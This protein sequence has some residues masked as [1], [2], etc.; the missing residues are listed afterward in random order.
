MQFASLTFLFLFFPMTLGLYRLVPHRWKREAMLVISVL[1][2][3]GGGLLSAGV[4]LLLT[5]L[6]FFAGWLMERWKSRKG[7]SGL[8]LTG[9]VLGYLAVLVLLRSDWLRS[10]K[11]A[12]LDGTMF[13]PLGLAFFAL[14]GVG[15]CADVRRG[16]I[17]AER[18]WRSFFLYMLFYPRLILGP[19]VSYRDAQR[20]EFQRAVSMEQT[21]AGLLR[22]VAGLAKK[23]LL[24]DW[25]GMFFLSAAQT[26]FSGYSFL[27]AWLG[28]LAHLLSLYLELSGYADMA[29]GLALCYGVK[30]PE[31]YGKKLFYPSVLLFSAQ[32]NRT[33]IQWF[34][35]Y[36]GGHLSSRNPLLRTIAVTLTWGCIGLWYGFRLPSLL[37]GIAIGLL[38][39]LE[40][41]MGERRTHTGFRYL[42]VGGLLSVGSLL[43]TMPDLAHVWSYCRILLGMEGIMPTESDFYF[44]RSYGLAL[45]PACYTAT[46]H[47]RTLLRRAEHTLW[48]RR[49]RTVL[50]VS[51]S[52]LLLAGCVA[53]LFGIGGSAAMQLLI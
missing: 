41:A 36:V 32:W 22:F 6:T 1:F 27:T 20:W 33:V 25:V 38:L 40:H 16:V 2:L 52:V 10:W 13:F 5:A 4:L 28:V 46:G 35:Q 3:L 19:A 23:L 9:V 8:L 7:R 47:W 24:A 49:M 12:Y 34:S 37:W 31:S 42:L 43:L 44:L 18:N 53:V 39:C 17:S 29:I 14:Q 51:V 21:G 45:L 15:Y 48:F 50:T 30:L 11:T 26:D